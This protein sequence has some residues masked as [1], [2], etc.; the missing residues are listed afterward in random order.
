MEKISKK[1]FLSKFFVVIF[2]QILFIGEVGYDRSYLCG[3]RS[4]SGF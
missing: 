1:A 3:R 2:D 4:Y